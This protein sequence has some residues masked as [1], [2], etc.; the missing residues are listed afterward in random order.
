MAFGGGGI[1]TRTAL[2]DTGC[3][4]DEDSLTSCV[5]TMFPTHLQ[6]T[7]VTCP[8]SKYALHNNTYLTDNK[9]QKHA[10]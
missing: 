10:V 1:T 6:D 7:G 3:E 8:E 4:G 5:S 2:G 9:H